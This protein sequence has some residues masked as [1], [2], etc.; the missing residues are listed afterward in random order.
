M[1]IDE[2]VEETRRAREEYAV[3]FDYDIAAIIADVKEKEKQ[4]ERPVVSYPP[5]QPLTMPIAKAS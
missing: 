2:I 1:L 5:K 4:G 3:R